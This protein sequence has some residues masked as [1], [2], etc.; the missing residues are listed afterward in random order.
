MLPVRDIRESFAHWDLGH[1]IP[2]TPIRAPKQ[3]F[4]SQR[5]VIVVAAIMGLS[6]ACSA[7][8]QSAA[9]EIEHVQSTPRQSLIVPGTDYEVRVGRAELKPNAAPSQ[10]L[11]RAIVSWLS[12]T[13]ELPSHDV[14]PRV[15]FAAAS[16]I[17]ALRYKNL[18]GRLPDSLMAAPPPDQREAV[19]IYDHQTMSIVLPDGWSGRSPAELSVLVHEMVHHLQNLGGLKFA[20]PQEREKLAYLAQERWLNLFERDL[21]RDFEIDGFT[22]LVTTACHG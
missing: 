2:P 7:Q 8:E 22:L 3:F 15:E 10:A 16:K 4:G 21:L 1:A 18:L 5:F 19:A 9:P 12:T 6:G 20:C 14:L 17:A 11:L 13:F